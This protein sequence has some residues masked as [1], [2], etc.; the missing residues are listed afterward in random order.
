MSLD[1]KNRM[2]RK[3]VR[4]HMANNRP[5]TQV[6]RLILVFG[7]VS[8][9]RDALRAVGK[10]VSKVSVY[11]WNHPRSRGGSGG[12]VPSSAMPAV[13]D[14]ARYLGLYLSAEYLDPR[15]SMGESVADILDDAKKEVEQPE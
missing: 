15:P 7:G 6:D 14:A 1:A 4:D 3:L 12:V 10:P 13:L 5:L 11:R 9:M 8:A 2:I